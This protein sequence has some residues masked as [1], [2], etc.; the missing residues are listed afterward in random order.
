MPLAAATTT[1]EWITA[2]GTLGTAILSFVAVV[3]SSLTA[4]TARQE[5]R[6]AQEALGLVGKPKMAGR[7]STAGPGWSDHPEPH[8]TASVW[9][10]SDKVAVDVVAEVTLWDG[11]VWH[12][13]A[14][15]LAQN[16]AGDQAPVRDPHLRVF[17]GPPQPDP[18][19]LPPGD[20]VETIRVLYR[21]EHEL[22]RWEWKRT[23]T[24][25]IQIRGDNRITSG[26]KGS[27]RETDVRLERK[28]GNRWVPRQRV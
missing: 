7:V 13:H 20:Y 2:W 15:R 6:Q 18:A 4:K 10:L 9:N 22:L 1:A 27:E 8:T 23:R 5:A 21:D 17:C 28:R 25:K 14:E 12:G 11:S 26:P 16:T 24:M 19:S 3:V